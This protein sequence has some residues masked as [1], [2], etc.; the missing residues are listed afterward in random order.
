MGRPEM[1]K[2]QV[3]IN[4]QVK[5]AWEQYIIEHGF[6]SVQSYIR[7]IAK[8]DVDGRRVNLDEGIE[9]SPEAAARYDKQ[10]AE[11]EELRK[12]GETKSYSDVDEMMKD[13]L[14]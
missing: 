2:M 12:Q 3:P 5:E 1:M 10:V 14:A 8:A 13:L 11:H 6:D 4:R 9:L 7:F